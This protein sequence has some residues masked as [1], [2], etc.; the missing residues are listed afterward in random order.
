MLLLCGGYVS[1]IGKVREEE[2]ERWMAKMRGRGERFTIRE[3]FPD[4]FADAS[5]NHAEDLYVLIDR[6][7]ELPL[8]FCGLAKRAL[9]AGLA[10]P[11][12]TEETPYSLDG[13]STNSWSGFYRSVDGDAVTLAEIYRLLP[14]PDRDLGE[15]MHFGMN[16]R[17]DFVRKRSLALQLSS[18][19]TIEL[20]RRNPPAAVA[21]M[22]GLVRL[23]H[24]HSEHADLVNCVFGAALLDLVMDAQWA[25]LQYPDWSDAQLLRWQTCWQ[26][27]RALPS[28]E[29]AVEVQRAYALEAFEMVRTNKVGWRSMIGSGS[30]AKAHLNEAF[31]QR[32]LADRDKLLTLRFHQIALDA[33]RTGA[34]EQSWLAF[35]AAYSPY[36]A[37]DAELN[38]GMGRYCT[39][40]HIIRFDADKRARKFF[41]LETRRVLLVTA[42]ALHRYR[43]ANGHFPMHLKELL[44]KYL[45]EEPREWMNGG[46]L[47]YQRGTNGWFQLRSFGENGL[48]E[49][50]SGDDLPW[51]QM[52]GQRR[53]AN[54]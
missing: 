29:R 54:P 7:D 45:L 53:H 6:L 4:G 12:W 25:I 22:D 44:P 17:P 21:A 37:L 11:L 24:W 43:L 9:G 34:K 26:T 19:V 10:R 16:A 28:L 40:T 30:S 31:R 32:F 51:W 20:N 23:T 2:A 33:L 36:W 35:R 42:I 49:L 15:T 1:W 39:L 52:P 41:E 46:P 5:T 38:R 18:I 8:Q 13:K 50:G 48:D 47:H 3:L 27:N 14:V